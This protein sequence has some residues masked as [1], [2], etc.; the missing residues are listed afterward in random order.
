MSGGK[1]SYISGISNGALES[2]RK[3]AMCSATMTQ[4]CH[5]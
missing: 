2:I 5:L 3:L 4:Q 1:V